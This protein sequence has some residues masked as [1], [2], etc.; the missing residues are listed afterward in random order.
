MKTKLLL[1]LILLAA[2]T[3]PLYARDFDGG[4]EGNEGSW[5]NATAWSPDGH[6]VPGQTVN[7]GTFSTY[8]DGYINYDYSYP[9]PLEHPL[10]PFVVGNI[11][12]NGG[13]VVSSGNVALQGNVT[14]Y[15][16]V[17]VTSILGNVGMVT[18]TTDKTLSLSLTYNNGYS[19]F[20]SGDGSFN[21]NMGTGAGNAYIVALP[22]QS[23]NISGSH[24]GAT[25]IFGGYISSGNLTNST[26][27]L[28]TEVIVEGEFGPEVRKCTPIY[29]GGTVGGLKGGGIITGS[30]T[31]GSN[32]ENTTFAGNIT[33]ANS[34]VK[35]KGTGE[36][37]LSG[38]CEYG[39]DTTVDGGHLIIDNTNA[40]GHYVINPGTTLT[41]GQQAVIPQTS[42]VENG[43]TLITNNMTLA[44]LTG[45][46]QT[47][48]GG[49][50][51]IGYGSTTFSYSGNISGAGG[52]TKLG[53]GNLTLSG[54]GTWS[55]T[56]TIEGGNLT[57]STNSLTNGKIFNNGTLNWNALGTRTFT[58]TITG[59]GNLTVQ[60][61][62]LE[63]KSNCDYAGTTEIYNDAT[64]RASNVTLGS[65]VVFGSSDATYDL[66]GGNGTINGLSSLNYYGRVT[67]GTNPDTT[68]TVGASTGDYTF[69][70]IIS[71]SGN[72]VKTGNNIQMLTNNNTYSG[73]TRVMGG[74][75]VSGNVG[76]LSPTSDVVVET[77]AVLKLITGDSIKTLRGGGTVDI[78]T[79]GASLSITSDKDTTCDSIFTGSGG[80]TKSG[81]G[82]M[83]LT[84]AGNMTGT[85]NVSGGTL[86]LQGGTPGE[87]SKIYVGS[88]NVLNIA[89]PTTIGSLDSTSGASVI[90]GG[91]LTTGGNNVTTTM[92]SYSSISGTGG[93]TKTGTGTF[94]IGNTNTYT[95]ATTVN[96]GTLKTSATTSLSNKTAVTIG[97]GG[98]LSIY[99]G[100]PTVK[101][102]AGTGILDLQSSYD[103][104]ITNGGTFGGTIKTAGSASTSD[105]K[106]LGGTFTI[107]KSDV[108][109]DY[110]Y[111]HVLNNA[112]LKMNDNSDTIYALKSSSTS[113]GAKIE[114]GSGRLG[115]NYTSEFYGV[116]SGAGGLTVNGGTTTL[117]GSNT[118]TGTD[119]INGTN[120]KLA[121]ARTDTWTHEGAITGTGTLELQKGTMV[122]GGAFG[123]NLKLNILAGATLDMNGAADDIG[124]LTG[125]GNIKLGA[126]MLA[127]GYNNT[128]DIFSGNITGI[129][130]LIKAGTA[131]LRL[132]GTNTYSGPTDI[133]GGTLAAASLSSFNGIGD[134]SA[135]KVAS[136][137]LLMIGG[138]GT[139]SAAT[140]NIGSLEG[141]GNTEFYAA[142]TLGTGINN[143]TTTY[144]GVLAGTGGGKLNKYGTGTMTLT[145][146][147]TY[148]GATAVK[149]GTL[150][151]SGGN[152]SILG[153]AA[154]LYD[155]GT[156]TLDNTGT[157]IVRY[158]TGKA[159]YLYGGTYEQKGGTQT[160]STTYLYGYGASTI[161]LSEG[162]MLTSSG[163]T[164]SSTG[165]TIDF[166]GV[167]AT[168]NIYRSTAN[169]TSW[170]SYNNI[171]PYATVN[172]ADFATY[173]GTSKIISAYT[174][175][176]TTLANSSTANFKLSGATTFDGNLSANSLVLNDLD[177]ACSLVGTGTAM[178]TS[179]AMIVN[180]A[181]ATL[182][183]NIASS[184][185]M[186]LFI[187][188]T[189]TITKPIAATSSN[190]IAKSGTGTLVVAPGGLLKSSSNGIFA[191]E[192]TIQYGTNDA[193]DGG[194]YV[195]G[196]TVDIGTFADT[197]G[198]ITLE[199]G[200]ITGSGSNLLTT[201]GSVTTVY[202]GLISANLAGTGGLTKA[203]DSYLGGTVVLS[204]Q[205]AYTG[206]TT[207]SGGT[208]QMGRSD[209]L[210]DVSDL[211]VS[212]SAAVLDMKGYVDGVN[213]LTLSSGLITGEEG[214]EIDCNSMTWS[215]GNVDTVKIVVGGTLTK[216]SGTGYMGG[217]LYA[218][219]LSMASG[220]TIDMQGND[221]VIDSLT[222]SG[223]ISNI[224]TMDLGAGNGDSTFA[225]NLTG[226]EVIK[227]GTGTATLTGTNISTG[228]TL[229]D[230]TLSITKAT[231]LT[232]VTQNGGTLILGGTNTTIT[233][234]GGT[235][236]DVVW[237]NGD[238]TVTTTTDT[239]IVDITGPGWL[240]KYGQARMDLAGQQN[241]IG[242]KVHEGTLAWKG[243]NLF[244]DTI[245][246]Y[247]M[248]DPSAKIDFGNYNDLIRD[249]YV[250]TGS[251]VGRGTLN[252][253]TVYLNGPGTVSQNVHAE[254][255]IMNTADSTYLTG[256]N[257]IIT[258]PITLAGGGI[259]NTQ[260]SSIP[261]NI[262]FSDA[263]T[264]VKFIQE[265]EGTYGHLISGSGKLIKAGLGK[266][267]LTGTQ[268][269]S[270]PTTV[271]EGELAV[272]GAIL[273]SDITVASGAVL[274]GTGEIGGM[275]E[276]L[277]GS[278]LSPGASPENLAFLND[279]IW[280]GG[281][282][283]TWEIDT[284]E[285]DGG[286]PG[287]DPGWDLVTVTDADLIINAT[288]ADKYIFDL[289][290][291]AHA[292]HA[293]AP[294]TNFDKTQNYSWL[295]A[296]VT[297]GAI[298]YSDANWWSVNTDNFD[299]D[300]TGGSF[301]VRVAGGTQMFI[302]YTG[303]GGGGGGDGGEG[304]DVPEPS[305]LLLL[306][307][308][309]GF[310]LRKLKRKNT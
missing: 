118:Y 213:K 220:S 106:I 165:R 38:A 188:G 242:V 252:C 22:T 287:N 77:G 130:G 145:A 78:Q 125:S 140:E 129:G 98:T 159:L 212:N 75:L 214:S 35:K 160:I 272:M 167:D 266:L 48:L 10:T 74:T 237:T 40:S 250:E 116:I 122:R 294:L 275:T 289:T 87:L 149:G 101:S 3:P 28:L 205:N 190:L 248:D 19:V 225:G 124:S 264:S 152:G 300:I 177:G 283:Y 230:G 86:K 166:S 244:A 24:T 263:G 232:N 132:S 110:L 246:M 310:G 194:L 5:A 158:G 162:A 52:F 309:I 197:V 196:G 76:G 234:G 104:S 154:H 45:S 139:G 33:G 243:N 144:N 231:G 174:G 262:T 164:R 274:S 146:S 209:V 13:S 29:T 270:G 73:T 54:T 137:A 267:K 123:D 90:L 27:N 245:D 307:P 97:N 181:N 208:L 180:G 109:D 259:L 64:L 261:V 16:S 186:N 216:S 286:S 298:T 53:T 171:L 79:G 133:M 39:G 112:T 69:T 169:P 150:V 25:E 227:N 198:T 51:A 61:G 88:N 228:M 179:G 42:V 226:S 301:S 71:G 235:G 93:L 94:T 2:L 176:I 273:N 55:G 95:G 60:G 85:V 81:T 115:L 256:T 224:G 277:S 43:G 17:G 215:S 219:T 182:N 290:T 136:G 84:G 184:A 41:F 138:D 66:N 280:N 20:G 103:L 96:G 302:D 268:T 202:N 271:E 296:Q 191:L 126:G 82:T 100:S 163:L 204:G 251:V 80:L 195:A 233:G 192:G 295:I 238:L 185:E 183:K 170:N 218:D 292:T 11:Y 34:Y 148:T 282:Y 269:Y 131:K 288:S 211:T 217:I 147:N 255:V 306:M 127:T 63:L 210:A 203:T 285:G 72:L 21:L 91:T 239:E 46:G 265:N 12:V 36:M 253:R 30:I 89:T 247:T 57:V 62:T 187:N 128:A 201:T 200:S 254:S 193:I 258:N 107:S 59:S 172:R 221:A 305:T 8:A 241:Y 1:I 303:T 23:V 49:D 279:V 105:L 70:G 102:L 143:G 142:S 99:G 299:N 156:L 67:L 276:F 223:S 114:L 111:V 141:D 119:E 108:F 291:L 151:L 278:Y 199:S 284:L 4:P 155:G 293:L 173:D 206:T 153:S 37:T 157:S 56:T 92:H 6:L 117:Y 47:I 7:I 120:T 14:G 229:N 161:A 304:G 260:A 178:L 26:L 68:L 44:Q 18:T 58:D 308:F 134:L 240:H 83:T 222:G 249:L 281:A 168:T 32:G 236:G 297:G 113:T 175:Y 257:N 207:V 9:N 135:V 65:V 50:L 15:G 31:A 189:T 121:F